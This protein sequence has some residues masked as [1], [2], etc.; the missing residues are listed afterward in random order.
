MSHIEKEDNEQEKN[1][2]RTLS[3]RF[4]IIIASV[5]LLSLN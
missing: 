3:R 1:I 2:K 4:D 5:N